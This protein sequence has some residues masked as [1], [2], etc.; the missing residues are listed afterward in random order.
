MIRSNYHI[1][2]NYCDGKNTLEEMVLAGIG[3][4]LISMGFSSHMPLPFENDWTMKEA[5]LDNY[6]KDLTYLKN[7]YAS[8]VELYC[9]L[10]ID[11]FIDRKDISAFSK[12]YISRLDYTI[13][14]IHTIG[15]TLSDN[16]LYVDESRDN[17]SK[18]IKKFYKN[19][20]KNFIKDYYE[21]IAQMVQSFKPDILG[22]LDLIKKFN[23]NNFFFDENEKWYQESI[24][25]CLDAV[26]KTKTMIEINTGA[27]LRVPGVG[28]YPSDWIIPEL[29]KRKIPITISGDSHSVEGISFYFKETE[30]F[31]MECGYKKYGMLKNGHWEM[32]PLGV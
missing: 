10:E 11:Y 2:S 31:L 20:T 1:H 22:H 23:K 21:G 25:Q 18:G 9:G 6:F 13:M 15:S 32:Q 8:A 3:A 26:A 12:K 27:N 24:T 29:Y 30:A 4:G 14:S 7:K 19:N 5:N 16:V 28:R 17:F